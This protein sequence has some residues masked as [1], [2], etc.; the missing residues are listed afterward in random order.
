M[1]WLYLGTTLFIFIAVAFL[2]E[3]LW[4]WWF[5]TQS[6]SAKRFNQRIHALGGADAASGYGGALLKQRRF[7][8]QAGVDRFLR[9][10]PIAESL[11]QQLQQAGSQHS[12]AR[13]L[14][15]CAAGF[16]IGLVIGSAIFMLWWM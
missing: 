12:V 3:A 10:W 8:R 14:A 1:N 15:Y 4:R 13:L 6:H 16:C 2:V 11:D 7:A 9:Q 5:S